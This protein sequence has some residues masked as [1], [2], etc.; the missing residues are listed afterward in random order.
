MFFNLLAAGAVSAA[1]LSACERD[2][3]PGAAPALEVRVTDVEAEEIAVEFLPGGGTVRYRYALG[4]EG[5]REDFLSGRMR[6]IVTADAGGT[7]EVRFD[8]LA[9]ETA[10]VVYAFALNSS[11]EKS[12]PQAV[13]VTTVSGQPSV[14]VEIADN[15]GTSI[16]AVFEPNRYA[17]A[18]R[19]ALGT[20]ADRAAFENGTMKGAV[21]VRGPGRVEYEFGELVPL[22]GYTLFTA[23]CD[24]SDEWGGVQELPVATADAPWAYV[25]FTEFDSFRARGVIRFSPICTG[26]NYFMIPE[27]EYL[28]FL[29]TWGGDEGAMMRQYEWAPAVETSF[30]LMEQGWLLTGRPGESKLIVGAV[31]WTGDRVPA[32]YRIRE[33][34]APAYDSSLPLPGKP[35]VEVAPEGDDPQEVRITVKSDGATAAVRIVNVWTGWYEENGDEGVRRLMDGALFISP[36]QSYTHNAQQ[37]PMEENMLLFIEAYNGNGV[38]GAK[39]YRYEYSYAEGRMIE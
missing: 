14:S 37:L 22:T 39:L 4:T 24:E 15:T 6:G 28:K 20:A 35:A 3:G 18:F 32:G 33:F 10:Y 7:D 34:T 29:A 21:T 23:A 12:E 26:A 1:L 8:G 25:E 2:D 19:Y 30:D 16:K 38:M 36:E 31:F 11:G 9:A 27:E 13:P 17:A 5:D